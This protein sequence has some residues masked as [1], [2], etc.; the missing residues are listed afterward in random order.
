MIS[1]GHMIQNTQRGANKT[2]YI[3][4]CVKMRVTN[5]SQPSSCASLDITSMARGNLQHDHRM[6]E[7]L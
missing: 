6:T 3:L 2:D 7:H 4:N 5:D 1:A